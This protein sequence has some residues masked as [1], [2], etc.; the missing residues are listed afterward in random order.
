MNNNQK[1]YEILGKN[2]ANLNNFKQYLPIYKKYGLIVFRN[3]F[4]NDKI[5]NDF[6]TDVKNL[7][8]VIIVDNKVKINLNQNLNK[9]ITEFSYIN[10]KDIG[11]IYDLGTRPLKLLSGVNLKTH[12]VISKLVK[13]LMSKKSII[14]NPY[15]GETLHIFPPGK[16]NYKHN[17]P[18]HQDYPY[19]MQS[20]EQITS[21]INLG[22]LQPQ[23]N[24][25]IKVWLGSHKD[26]VTKSKIFSDGTRITKNSK[27]YLKKYNSENFYFDKGDFAIFNSLMHHEGILNHSNCTRIVQLVRYSNLL[28]KKSISYRWRST[29]ENKKRESIKFEDEH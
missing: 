5:F 10:R 3:F 9:L 2:T 29:E 17:L 6:Y 13:T 23:G 8:K 1:P 16:E 7:V 21:Y 19:I 28:N 18:M 15:L 25:G 4:K 12:P 27:Y 20:P 24:G 22:K 26:G 14:G 11:S